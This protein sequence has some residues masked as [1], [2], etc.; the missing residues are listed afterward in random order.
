MLLAVAN[1]PVGLGARAV[2][3]ATSGRAVYV[4]PFRG[5]VAVL[6]VLAVLVFVWMMIRR[7]AVGSGDSLAGGG[8]AAGAEAGAFA[9]DAAAD[10]AA[11][12]EAG[13]GTGA[14]AAGGVGVG[15]EER[16]GGVGG[17]RSGVG[18]IGRKKKPATM[19][20]FL[21][22]ASAPSASAPVLAS[23]G[24]QRIPDHRASI[25]DFMEPAPASGGLA[26]GGGQKRKAA[27][28]SARSCR[29]TQP[30]VSSIFFVGRAALLERERQAL[31]AIR[32]IARRAH[33]ERILPSLLPKWNLRQ[34]RELAR[35]FGVPTVFAFDPVIGDNVP[36]IVGYGADLAAPMEKWKAEMTQAAASLHERTRT[37][38]EAN[39]EQ[40]PSNLPPPEA[41]P[42]GSETLAATSEIPASTTTAKHNST[43]ARLLRLS[44][45]AW[46][47]E[48][49]LEMKRR[50][51]PKLRWRI[52]GTPKD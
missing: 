36:M 17:R 27:A 8:A 51:D 28:A 18:R 2:V 21:V 29:W 50:A 39:Q 46:L 24:R 43:D 6:A 44:Y 19:L 22:P 40:Q 23:E 12:A 5:L 3:A 4:P 45:A 33:V 38:D 47:G 20:R 9:A 42:A 32:A 25:A 7:R 34:G 26:R 1:L 48:L 14:G 16:R 11:G 15:G 49:H 37:D 41:E 52:F 30:T 35:V 31:P 10:V 13:A